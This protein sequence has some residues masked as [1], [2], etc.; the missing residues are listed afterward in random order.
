MRPESGPSKL[1]DLLLGCKY[2]SEKSFQLAAD[3]L[4]KESYRYSLTFTQFNLQCNPLQIE[5]GLYYAIGPLNDVWCVH[6]EHTM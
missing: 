4:I 1:V 5:P 3:V 2:M 6:C